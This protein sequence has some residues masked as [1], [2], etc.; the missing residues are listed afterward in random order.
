MTTVY[1]QLKSNQPQTHVFI[2]GV[3]KYPYLLGGVPNLIIDEPM[4]LR[5]LSSPPISARRFADWIINNLYNPH[6]PL[7]S[8]EMLLSSTDKETYIRDGEE[9]EVEQATLK[10]VETAFDTWYSRCD[11]DS[12]NVAIFYFCG[13]G[14]QKENLALLLEDFGKDNNR[15]FKNAINFD[16]T[17]KGMKQCKANIQCYFVDSCRDVPYNILNYFMLDATTLI[18]P[19]IKNNRRENFDAPILFASASDSRAYGLLNQTTRFTEALIKGLKGL[20][21]GHIRGNWVV[22]TDHLCSAVARMVKRRNTQVHGREQRCEGDGQRALDPSCSIIHCLKD[23]PSVPVTISTQPVK[24]SDYA[25]FCIHNTTIHHCRSRESG[26]WNLDIKADIYKAHA[27]F[28]KGEFKNPAST[29]LIVHPP[30]IEHKFE[31]EKN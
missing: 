16:M 31:V 20:G 24:A 26:D 8:V 12:R 28:P 18:T 4:G 29:N 30:Y 11:A 17:Y 5:Q 25:H 10:N 15:P 21:S 7:G 22:T 23:A 14:V 1:K 27:Y 2:I 13:H 19:K 6:A 3:G 9:I